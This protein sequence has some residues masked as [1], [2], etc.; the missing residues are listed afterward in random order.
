MKLEIMKTHITNK[1][2]T[3]H[4]IFKKREE[5]NWNIVW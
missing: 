2:A 4:H 5:F 3:I 1:V